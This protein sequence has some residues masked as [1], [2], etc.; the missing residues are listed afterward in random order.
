MVCHD[1]HD[2]MVCHAMVCH[3]THDAMVCHDTHDAMVCHDSHDAM[4]WR[5][6]PWWP[7][8]L[9]VVPLITLSIVFLCLQFNNHLM[10]PEC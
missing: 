3:D 4:V 8:V 7:M 6:I 1:A 9:H 5:D 2:A 10:L